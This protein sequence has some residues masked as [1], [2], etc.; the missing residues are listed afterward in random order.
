MPSLISSTAFVSV[1]VPSVEVPSDFPVVLNGGMPLGTKIVVPCRST[2]TLQFAGYVTCASTRVFNAWLQ[3]YNQADPDT[4]FRPVN[5]S[6]VLCTA[7]TEPSLS[8]TVSI[9]PVLSA[10]LLPGTYYAEVM[11]GVVG[12]PVYVSAGGE[13]SIMVVA[14]GGC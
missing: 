1:A 14:T 3:L 10:V 8:G 9:T 2:V 5:P 4:I 6:A 12:G 11:L 13:L 7:Y